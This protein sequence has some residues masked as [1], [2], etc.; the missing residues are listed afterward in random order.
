MTLKGSRTR[1]GRVCLGLQRPRV[2]VFFLFGPP[3]SFRF[4]YPSAHTYPLWPFLSRSLA[5]SLSLSPLPSRSLGGSIRPV[6]ATPTA[7]T[8]HT[9]SEILCR[10]FHWIIQQPLHRAWVPIH[11]SYLPPRCSVPPHC[12]RPAL[13]LAGTALH[14]EGVHSACRPLAVPESPR[15][16]GAFQVPEDGPFL[17]M[18][19]WLQT[20]GAHDW[21]WAGC[22]CVYTARSSLQ[23]KFGG[24]RALAGP[25]HLVVF[26]LTFHVAQRA[27]RRAAAEPSS[28]ATMP[29]PCSSHPAP[30]PAFGVLNKLH[31]DA[32]H[33]FRVRGR[34]R[35]AVGRGPARW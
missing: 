19:F 2:V 17:P 14:A 34:E 6:P 4:L 9:P 35:A 12:P 16:A 20:R 7:P 33:S 3:S 25:S 10:V 13:P 15:L 28:H 8:P 23:C 26:S 27:T 21:A 30:R 22:M 32:V 29:R 11:P 18:P 31:V 24:P 5:P 1:R